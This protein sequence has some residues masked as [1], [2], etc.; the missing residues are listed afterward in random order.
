MHA[1]KHAT[2][3]RPCPRGV[4]G[5][6]CCPAL[7]LACQTTPMHH[8]TLLRCPAQPAPSSPVYRGRSPCP[9]H[10]RSVSHSRCLHEST[11]ESSPARARATT[12]PP[13][14]TR[15][16]SSEAAK[17]RNSSSACP[18]WV[19]CGPSPSSGCAA[20][21]RPE[22]PAPPPP[23]SIAVGAEVTASRVSLDSSPTFSCLHHAGPTD[24]ACYRGGGASGQ[25]GASHIHA[26]AQTH[27]HPTASPVAAHSEDLSQV[28]APPVGLARR[29]PLRDAL[30]GAGRDLLTV[31]RVG[32]NGAN[33]ARPCWPCHR[34]QSRR[35][36]GPGGPPR[37]H[38]AWRPAVQRSVRAAAAAALTVGGS[39]ITSLS[40][41]RWFRRVWTPFKAVCTGRWPRPRKKREAGWLCAWAGSA[42][43]EAAPGGREA[44]LRRPYGCSVCVKVCETASRRAAC[45]WRMQLCEYTALPF[46]AVGVVPPQRSCLAALTDRLDSRLE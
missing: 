39:T 23:P 7:M 3:L 18:T 17:A 5:R 43:R 29:V 42:A 2:A 46:V 22:C 34:R 1:R 33:R 37:P 4:C 31:R 36:V 6:P 20:P 35:S 41:R 10:A 12:H 25:A 19:G 30:G 26:H 11:H 8:D 9:P 45:S 32:G 15:S 24:L 44:A 14:A 13:C 21:P 28:G 38:D 27:Q 16:R 40:G